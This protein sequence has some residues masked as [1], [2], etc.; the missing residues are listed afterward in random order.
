MRIDIRIPVG[1]PL[2]ELGE[3][4]RRCEAAGFHG[5]GIH[6][7]HHTGRDVYMALGQ[8]AASTS[9]LHLY[10]ATS[11]TI[12]R[13]PMVIA[14]L[15][16]SLCELAPG[17]A[18]VTLAPGFLSVEQA[19]TR[20]ARRKQLRETITAI[21]KLLAGEPVRLDG[22]DIEMQR[23]APGAPEVLLLASGPRLLEL[24]G[25]VADGAIMLVGLDPASVGAARAHLARGARRA[26]R[27]PAALHE[28]LIVPIAIGEREQVRE[29]PRREFRPGQTWLHYPS[30]SNI[31]WLREA[32]IAIRDEPSEMSGADAERVCDALGLFGPAEHC[33]DRLLRARE[34]VGLDHAFLFPAHT[35]ETGYDIPW[36][37][38]DAFER[39][40]GPRL[41]A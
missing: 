9:R 26:G 3:V 13:H 24:A 35:A 34:E 5:I 6:D 31:A 39:R 19:G 38:I 18:M 7:H 4:A 11:N 25:E 16:H 36:E 15:V 17:R 40:I 30:R 21:R 22:R 23:A 33:A 1:R 2:P 20:P 27:D 28:V 29:W 8:A 14:A 41:P 10:P 12:T 32:G 37:E